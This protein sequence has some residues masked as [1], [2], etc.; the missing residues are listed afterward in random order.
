M[1]HQEE[2]LKQLLNSGIVDMFLEGH[3]LPS[4]LRVRSLAQLNA[5][6]CTF[7]LILYLS[8]YSSWIRYHRKNTL[9]L[10]QYNLANLS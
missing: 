5:I 6:Y 8:F 2:K 7:R 1:I 9:D 4:R 10:L 3:C